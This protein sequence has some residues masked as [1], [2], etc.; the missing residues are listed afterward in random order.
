[1]LGVYKRI[2]PCLLQVIQEAERGEVRVRGFSGR[3]E[4]KVM[5]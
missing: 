1:M 3:T 4:Y 5:L 2:T